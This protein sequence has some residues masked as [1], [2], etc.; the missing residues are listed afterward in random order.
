MRRWGVGEHQQLHTL[1]LQPALC[2]TIFQSL[3]F[4]HEKQAETGPT[5]AR[6]P[7]F[8]APLR[9]HPGYPKAE[10]RRSK[11]G[12]NPK[13]ESTQS[14]SESLVLALAGGLVGMVLAVIGVRTLV[15]LTPPGLP[16]AD[17]IGI[18]TS[19]FLFGL[20]VT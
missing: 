1:N 20:A 7:T 15:A 5:G 16:R 17:A 12:R 18:D 9:P 4:K 19:V 2:L 11:E 8:S 3:N 13:T 14:R 10:I 6:E